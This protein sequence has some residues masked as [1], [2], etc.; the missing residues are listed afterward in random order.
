MAFWEDALGS[1]VSGDW[2]LVGAASTSR[3]AA[4]I[5]R[6]VE[7]AFFGNGKAAFMRNARFIGRTELVKRIA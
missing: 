2:A 1:V 5:T 4:A 7:R 3:T 6:R